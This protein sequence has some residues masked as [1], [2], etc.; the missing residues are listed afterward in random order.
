MTAAAP[1]PAAGWRSRLWRKHALVIAALLTLAIVTFGGTEMGIAYRDVEAQVGRV[2]QAQAHQAA[3]AVRGALTNIRRQVAAVTALPWALDDQLTLQTRREEYARLLR[4]LPA[5]EAVVYV[6]AAGQS[7]L[8]V[9]RREAD[10]MVAASA[11]PAVAARPALQPPPALHAA[12]GGVDYVADY[13]P[14]LALDLSYPESA[15][16]GRTQVRI[17]LRTLAREL[18]PALTTPDA[19]VY[20]ADAAGVPVLHRDPQVMLAR[21]PR[22]VPEGLPG[23]VATRG[24]NPAGHE[25]LV[26]TE[27]LPELGWHV[28]VEQPLA[29]A[30]RPVRATLWR[31]A[32]F[33]AGG[34]LLA[35][36]AALYLAGRLTRP[37]LD[38]YRGAEAIGAGSMHTRLAVHTGDELEALAGQFNRMAANLQESYAVLEH[39]VREKTLHLEIANRHK[40]EFLANMS[41]EL[42]TPLNAIIGFSEVLK[43][44]M[45]GP[46]NAKQAEYSSDIHASGEHLLALINDI[47]DLSKIEAGQLEL[48][49]SEFDVRAAVSAAVAL[50]RERCLRQRIQLTVTLADDVG[51]WVADLR[52]IKQVLV[53]LLA[54]AVKFTPAGGAIAL[55]VTLHAEHG[56]C[57][58]VSDTGIGIAPEHHTLVFQEFRQVGTDGERKAEGSGLGLALVKRLVEQHGGHVTLHSRLGAGTTLRFNIPRG[59][60]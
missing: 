1:R 24:V 33:T 18:L 49:P 51:T 9:S 7:R 39:R 52:R 23:A 27:A 53:N 56:L 43:E 50:V 17:A 55:G 34:V 20:V 40:S 11:A 54:N 28:V 32:A 25:V 8:Q 13:E 29:Q 21:R 46:L 19:E 48:E 3:Q 41:H 59:T 15:G 45:F 6:D 38:L 37:M 5:V 42:R 26:S 58:E 16:V 4:L 57:I 36:A 31:T 35:L 47:L 10:H 22:A 30:M 2:Q 60:P 14:M 12:Y 44:Q